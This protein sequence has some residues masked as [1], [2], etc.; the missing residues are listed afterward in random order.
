[1]AR[2]PDGGDA[3]GKAA[4]A[5]MVLA[6]VW[7]D[8]DSGW[9]EFN[10]RVLAE[11][12]DARTPPLERVKFLAIF[13]SNLDEFFMKRVALIR[14]RLTSDREQR[15]REIRERL[16]PMLQAQAAC[17]DSLLPSLASHGVRLLAWK[18]LDEAQRS[19]L[20]R[21]FDTQVSSALTPLFIKP[22]SS[23]CSLSAAIRSRP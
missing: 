23:A 17:F 14:E 16:V 2:P 20:S 11:A 22:K 1:M 21:Y 3:G 10:R 12:E 9:L 6:A 19:E 15:I 8:R 5:E 18:D 4:T 13:S 7:M